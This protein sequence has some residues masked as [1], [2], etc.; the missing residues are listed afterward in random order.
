MNIVSRNS[1]TQLGAPLTYHK[2]ALSFYDL[3]PIGISDEQL[4]LRCMSADKP[5][6]T[7]EKT[8]IEQAGFRVSFSGKDVYPDSMS[9]TFLSTGEGATIEALQ[10][11]KEFCCNARSGGSVAPEV[12]KATCAMADLAYDNKTIIKLYTC[13][14][15]FPEDINFSDGYSPSVDGQIVNVTFNLDWWE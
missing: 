5:S 9:F 3:P 2:Y 8:N 14:G 6:V 13:Y 12:Y 15:F 11:W 10:S 7:N 1:L 4:C